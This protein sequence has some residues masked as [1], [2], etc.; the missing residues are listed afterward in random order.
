[1]GKVYSAIP[2]FIVFGLQRSKSIG[3][4]E[5]HSSLGKEKQRD[6]EEQ[7]LQL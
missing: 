5:L 7:L 6:D 3:C 1:M 4:I 2:D